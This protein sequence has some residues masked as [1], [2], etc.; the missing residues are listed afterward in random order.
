MRYLAILVVAL[1][2]PCLLYAQPA[3]AKRAITVADYFTQADLFGIA[4]S[5]KWIAYT[6]GRWQESTDDR[7]TELWI[8]PTQGGPSR[9]LTADRASARSLQ[10]DAKGGEV[11][12][13]ANRKRD[14]EKRPPYDGKAQVWCIA[15]DGPAV[16]EPLTR[17]DGGVEAYQISLDGQSLYYLVHIDR[18]EHDEF[19]LRAKFSKLDYGH[20][21][22][23][24]GQIWKLDLRSRRSEK[25]IDA[26]RNIREFSVTRDQKRI[27]MITTPDDKVVSFEGQS[28]VDVW[29]A[30]AKKIVTLPEE[31]YRKKV[32][33]PY[34]WLEH[35]AW[36]PIGNKLAFNVIFDGYP[37][38]IFIG[39]LAGETPATTKMPRPAGVHIRGY[40]SPIVWFGQDQF[41][42]LAE[43]KARV[44]LMGV[45]KATSTTPNY[46]TKSSGDVVVEQFALAADTNANYKYAVIM[47]TPTRLPDV[48][49]SYAINLERLTN[50]NPQVS[51]WKLPQ[52]SV[53]S[54]KGAG[55][56]AVEGILEL[57]HDYKKGDKV[58]LV[59][60]IHGG[61]TTATY[62]KLQYWIYGR[63]LLPSRGYAVFCPNYRGSTGYGDKFTADLIG[64]ENDLDVEDILSGV[65]A[66]V[67]RGIAD[68]DKLAVSGWSNGG[69]LTNCIITKTNRFKAA[70]SGA[71]IVDA[72]MEWGANDEPAYTM[73]FKQGL[74]W[75]NPMQYH[76]ASPTYD[77]GKVRTPTLIHVGANDERCPPAQSRMLYRALKENLNVPAELIVYPGEAHGLSK[78]RNRQAKL[79]WDLAWLDRYVL[80]KKK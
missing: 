55:G 4:Y 73:V 24:I 45:N 60:E 68:P 56:Q 52:L 10:F 67:Q 1:L 39:D 53:V 44:R 30:A 29:T 79:E 57:P 6:E 8:V 21:Q 2:V 9:R 16:A 54:W 33:S 74:P 58:P 47:A 43:E 36:N 49:A 20:G 51:E 5:E 48:S 28:R 27:A 72:V 40:G 63:T 75:T 71:G 78:Y 61:P 23:R 46:F 26:G 59:V 37:A 17:V 50:V 41:Y 15:T 13:L 64:R 70:I 42:F 32:S 14:G 19:G 3:P 80:G 22:N 62:F 76:K 18:I 65:D 12:Y 38:E 11:Y 69:Y 77:L 66:L 25:L 31:G 34:A 35:V 7:K